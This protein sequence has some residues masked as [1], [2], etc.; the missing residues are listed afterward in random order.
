[1]IEVGK[2]G[3]Y[4]GLVIGSPCNPCFRI[5]CLTAH[6]LVPLQLTPDTRV[7]RSALCSHRGR[8]G[9]QGVFLRPV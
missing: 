8:A 2:L 6:R 5:S 4:G 9:S 7:L 1:M 3:S